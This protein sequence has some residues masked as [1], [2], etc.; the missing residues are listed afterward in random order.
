M[1]Y[2]FTFDL[3]RVS[4]S[5]FREIA[6]TAKSTNVHRKISHGVLSLIDKFKVHEITGLDVQNIVEVVADLVDIQ[7]KNVTNRPGFIK[8]KK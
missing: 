4:Q 6:K 5:F 7:I 3:T 2:K 8:G 1:A